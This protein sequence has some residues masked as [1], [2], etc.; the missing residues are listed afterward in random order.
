VI[1]RTKR[2]YEARD[3]KVPL[4]VDGDVSHLGY[5]YGGTHR[6]SN[7]ICTSWS[8]PARRMRR[9]PRGPLTSAPGTALFRRHRLQELRPTGKIAGEHQQYRENCR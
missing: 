7:S 2:R 6:R 5:R 4:S 1:H 3:P 8:D 9:L